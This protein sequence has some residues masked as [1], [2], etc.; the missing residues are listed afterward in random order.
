M[1]VSVGNTIKYQLSYKQAYPQVGPS[2]VCAQPET[3][4]PDL[5]GK[6]V[7]LPSITRIYGLSQF[8]FGSAVIFFFFSKL[9][10]MDLNNGDLGAGG[11][12]LALAKRISLRSSRISTDFVEIQPDLDIFPRDLA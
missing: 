11:G 1:D 3:D 5:G 12:D 9:K 7:D 8:W 6:D 2:W 4:P 10:P